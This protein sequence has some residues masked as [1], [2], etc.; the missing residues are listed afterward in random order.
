MVTWRCLI[1]ATSPGFLMQ[2]VTSAS[3]SHRDLWLSLRKLNYMCWNIEESC[4]GTPP[5]DRRANHRQAQTV[6]E[7][8]KLTFMNNEPSCG[9]S[10]AAS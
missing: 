9:P 7:T 6:Q 4:E 2:H 3:R 10:S 8:L 1:V 5:E